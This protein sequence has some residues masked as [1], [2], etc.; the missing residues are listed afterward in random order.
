MG[1]NVLVAITNYPSTD[2]T[3]TFSITFGSIPEKPI[4]VAY[5]ESFAGGNFNVPS[6]TPGTYT[7]TCKDSSSLSA[8]TTFTVTKPT[9]GTQTKAPTTN[10]GFWTLLTTAIVAAFSAG[11][12]CF[13]VYF[14]VNRR[15][16]D[17]PSVASEKNSVDKP[18]TSTQTLPY[19]YKS[20]QETL[21]SQKSEVPHA[22]STLSPKI[23]QAAPNH[24]QPATL[25]KMCK[26][27]KR[28]VRDDL[29]ICP[30]CMKK[31]K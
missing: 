23:N 24:S 14:Y 17:K 10:A 18:K 19:R 4:E 2:S 8:T 1:T 27:C 12:T 28:Q 6:V 16:H 9:F 15:R 3:S 21:S 20:P 11:A 13:A 30:Y 25:T 5:W 7:V 22:R 31:L 26:H 29:N